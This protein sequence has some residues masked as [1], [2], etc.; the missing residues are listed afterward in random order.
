LFLAILGNMHE[1]LT[2]SFCYDYVPQLWEASYNN[3][4]NSPDSNLRNFSSTKITDALQGLG[5]L[6]K[7]VYSL[8]EKTEVPFIEYK[9]DD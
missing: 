6:L 2:R 4:Y 9:L 8:K 1:M 7:R 5:S 3:I